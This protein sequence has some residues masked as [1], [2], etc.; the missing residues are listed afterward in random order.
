MDEVAE[1]KNRLNIVDVIMPYVTLKKTGKSY[2]G[3]CPFHSEKSPSFI[4]TPELGIYKCFGCGEA[5]DIFNFVEKKEG[6]E[7]AEALHMLADKAGVKLTQKHGENTKPIFEANKLAEKFYRY[8]LLKTTEGKKAL[9]YL[10]KTRQLS[11]KTIEEFGIGYS[12]NSWDQT[13]KTL[14]NKGIKITDLEQAGLVI[15]KDN[16]YYDRFRGRVMF[17]FYDITGRVIGFSAR[18]LNK[19][20]GAKYINTPETKIFT[21]GQTLYG[22]FTNKK[23]IRDNDKALIVEGQM[24]VIS[25]NKAGFN[26]AVA[27]GGTA[28][29]KEQLLLI[30]RFTNNIV[31]SFDSDTAGINA[32]KKSITLAEGLDI[33]I[34]VLNL[35][36][37]HDPDDAIKSSIKKF[38]TMIDTSTDAYNYLINSYLKENIDSPTKRKQTAKEVTEIISTISDPI[39]RDYYLTQLSEV[40]G[41]TKSNIRLTRSTQNNPTPKQIEV[42]GTNEEVIIS[43]LINYPNFI[44]KYENEIKKAGIEVKITDKELKEKI[45]MLRAGQVQDDADNELTKRLST[46]IT[47][48][49]E[50][51]LKEASK[52]GNTENINKIVSEIKKIKK[53]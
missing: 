43:I 31:L 3:N 15:K 36:N 6:I 48:Q 19:D 33:N 20:D 53:M 16:G 50:K 44:T 35:E 5:G 10:T 40:L 38:E 41:V 29:T 37:Y 51:D 11:T 28:L 27:P 1:I 9:E 14:T 8:C 46:I 30:K 4:V 17:P 26:F 18:T 23:G 42:K 32:L 12:P 52:T 24:D 47:K 34:K 45:T 21:K 22:L 49:F 13:Y 25:T 39:N 2:K 7:F